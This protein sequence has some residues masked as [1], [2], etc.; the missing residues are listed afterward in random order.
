MN[1]VVVVI[2]FNLGFGVCFK[3]GLLIDVDLMLKRGDR[4][5]ALRR[6]ELAVMQLVDLMMVSKLSL[7][8]ASLRM[9]LPGWVLL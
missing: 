2:G 7:S 8:S 9:D 4:F 3:A 5:L 1:G 6:T